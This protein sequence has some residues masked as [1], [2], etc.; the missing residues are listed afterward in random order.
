MSLF[1]EM[2]KQQTR[3]NKFEVYKVFYLYDLFCQFDLRL[4]QKLVSE[5]NLHQEK[6]RGHHYNYFKEWKNVKPAYIHRFS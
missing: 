2:R 3:E 4:N 5:E 1:L 6:Q